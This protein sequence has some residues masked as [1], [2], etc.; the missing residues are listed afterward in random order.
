M[1]IL[2][3]LS[4][5]NY[6]RGAGWGTTDATVAVAV[7]LAESG[8]NTNA[9]ATKGEDSRG[10]W[11]INVA[12]HPQLGSSNLYDPAVN[13]QAAFGIWK[14]SGWGPWSAHNN[15]SYLLF[16]PVAAA[17][18]AAAIPVIGGAGPQLLNNAGQGA[19]GAGIT[20][21]GSVINSA[22]VAGSFLSDL[23]NPAIWSR[24]LKVT[25]GGLLIIGALY[26]VAR[27]VVQPV[28]DAGVAVG[29]AVK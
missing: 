24:V 11:Q 5:A 26:I 22:Q 20:A 12:A 27:P 7:A 19:Y 6:A 28:V 9:H 1:T 21:A 4:V 18:V 10:L 2:T 25:V 8:G 16:M 13:A 15:G 29:K 17:S 23:E 14:T 3:P